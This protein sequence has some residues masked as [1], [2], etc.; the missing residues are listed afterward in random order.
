MTRP[1]HTSAFFRVCRGRGTRAS[2]NLD[3]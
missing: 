2:P 1:A 3:S